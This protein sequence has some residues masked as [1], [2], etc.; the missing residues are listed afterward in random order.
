MGAGLEREREEETNH[1][2]S[3]ARGKMSRSPILT[4]PFP[5]DDRRV[6]GK[7][8]I[9]RT[10]ICVPG[11]V[12]LLTLSSAYKVRNVHNSKGISREEN[13]HEDVEDTDRRPAVVDPESEDLPRTADKTRTGERSPTPAPSSNSRGTGSNR[14]PMTLRKTA[15][16]MLS[17]SVSIP[18]RH[19]AV[20]CWK[21]GDATRVEGTFNTRSSPVITP[22]T[23]SG[24]VDYGTNT[25]GMGMVVVEK[26]EGSD[27]V[28][29][30]L[31]LPTPAKTYF[32]SL[33]EKALTQWAQR[34]PTVFSENPPLG[35]LDVPVNNL[36]LGCEGVL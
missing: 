3:P 4:V 19:E 33:R 2:P 10:W 35:H 25:R 29:N 7:R 6:G 14:S 23:T 16:V 17:G 20:R 8:R 26:K 1:V 31:T 27:H 15:S 9:G 28:V 32:A 5:A 12:S 18:K 30:P 13:Q 22:D 34:K 21:G 36:Q 11:S 24:S